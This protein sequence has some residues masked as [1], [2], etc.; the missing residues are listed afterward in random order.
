M[1]PDI[2][3]LVPSLGEWQLATVMPEAGE[4]VLA[5]W[6]GGD[7]PASRVV[8]RV[9]PEWFLSEDAS[10]VDAPDAWAQIIYPLEGE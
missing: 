3:T 4:N 10:A 1:A 9:G 6:Y 7:C 8:F 5:Y 2:L